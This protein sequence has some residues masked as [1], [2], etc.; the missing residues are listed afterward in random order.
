M[1]MSIQTPQSLQHFKMNF[2]KKKNAFFEL[3]N[4]RPATYKTRENS[5]YCKNTIS[6]YF[7]QQQILFL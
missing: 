4:I 6:K 5:A 7:D 3:K 2:V 1:S